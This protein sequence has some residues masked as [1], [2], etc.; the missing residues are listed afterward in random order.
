MANKGKINHHL[1]HSHCLALSSFVIHKF[2]HCLYYSSSYRQAHCAGFIGRK[3]ASFPPGHL[4]ERTE[5]DKDRAL[6]YR[7]IRQQSGWG[8]GY[9]CPE[10]VLLSYLN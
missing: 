5:S 1:I 9:F 4:Y 10:S 2:N 7:Y 6:I 3:T 8:G